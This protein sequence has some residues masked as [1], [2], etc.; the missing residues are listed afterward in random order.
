M[1]Q[2]SYRS[3]H[4]EDNGGHEDQYLGQYSTPDLPQ[5]LVDSESM[6]LRNDARFYR[7][8]TLDKRLKAF[9][10][11]TVLA[12]LMIGTSLGQ[13]MM[14]PH[15]FNFQ[16]VAGWAEMASF[17]AFIFT[18]FFNV[19]TMFVLVQQLFFTYRLKT[20][21]YLGFE[22]AASYY[23]NRNIVQYR[24]LAIKGILVSF[25]VFIAGGALRMGFEFYADASKAGKPA[26]PAAGDPSKELD[27]TVHTVLA[28]SFLAVV[29]LFFLFLCCIYRRHVAIFRERYQIVYQEAQPLIDHMTTLRGEGTVGN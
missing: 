3:I 17:L 10:S 8:S 9:H 4:R 2:D 18:F 1:S 25:P 16:T 20:A 23:L 24:H 29:V 28:C 14:M 13:C 21:G 7:H 19:F 5:R 22:V 6:D 27:M 26:P 11:L 15:S 12:G